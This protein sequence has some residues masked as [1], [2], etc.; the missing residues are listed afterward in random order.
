MKLFSLKTSRFIFHLL[1]DVIADVVVIVV[2]V[3][4]VLDITP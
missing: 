1:I 2:V 3:V 4:G